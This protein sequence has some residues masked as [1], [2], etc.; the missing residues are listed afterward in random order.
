MSM[1]DRPLTVVRTLPLLIGVVYG[2]HALADEV[3]LEE[4]IVT[5]Q[6]RTERLQDVPLSIS[7]IG[8]S[9]L[10]TRGLE[11]A[12]NIDG[13]VPNVTIKSA[14]STGLIAATAI[15]GLATGQPSIWADPSVGL[16]LDGVFVG[17][18]QGSLFDIA[19]LER[20]EVL[21]GPQG[22]LFGRNTEGGAINFV[23][24]KPGGVFSG[25]V[26]FELGNYGRHVERVSMDLP[27]VGA[28]SISFALR[29]ESQDGWLKNAAGQDFNGKD[30]QAGRLAVSF[31]ISP[32]FKIDYAYDA[33]RI[34]ESPPGMTL[35]D[36]GGYGKYYATSR[37]TYLLFQRGL[38]IMGPG[39]FGPCSASNPLAC[40]LD[41][42]ML[43]GLGQALAATGAAS[44]SYPGT[45]RAGTPGKKYY[46]KLDV[47]GHALTATY[48]L[49]KQ[50]TLKYIGAYRKMDY[51]DM[52]DIDGTTLT[53]YDTGRDTKYSTYSHEFQWV[54]TTDRLNY[55]IGYYQFK[56]DGNSIS[57]NGGDMLTFM[58]PSFGPDGFGYERPGFQ[59]RTHAKALYGQVDYKVTDA[60]TAT[61]G[62]RRTTEK[63]SGSSVRYT[64][65][66]TG[67]ITGFQ[68]DGGTGPDYGT[69]CVP[70]TRHSATDT[71]SANTP[72]LALAYR[73]NEN[74]NVFGRAAK[75]FKSGGFSLEATTIAGTQIPFKPERSTSY[76]V[77]IKTNFWGG[78]GQFNAT[79]FR[80]NVTDLQISQMPPGSNAGAIIVNA[81][82]A[83]SQ[84]I[85]L[86]SAFVLADGWKLQANYGYLD[87]KFRKYLTNNQFG[88]LVDVAANTVSPYAPKSQFNV[89]LDGR[90][91]R[92]SLGTLRGIID[93]THSAKFYN[94][95]GQIS[96]PVGA[97]SPTELIAVANTRDE[98]MMPAITNVNARLLLSGIRV[99]GP[100]A[101]DLSLWVRNLTNSHKMT[102]HIDVGGFY[103]IAT[104]QDPR[105]YGMSLNYKW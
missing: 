20:I 85:E 16:Y 95:A 84:G 26:G 8:G 96:Q 92:T 60:L 79:V 82:S 78:K 19:D 43:T 14:P 37:G 74:V 76:E 22:T 99:G 50:N 93:V 100:G 61:L 41:A 75:G 28:A 46:Q 68:C 15:R 71:S 89:N 18:N 87:A 33:T 6:K 81:G 49:N 2:G 30:R 83:R 73:F 51:R 3:K 39:A 56:D 67:A 63:K 45:I 62:Y 35:V 59:V 80:T 12:R 69:P 44:T 25:N 38:N 11:S 27:K 102:S 5:A 47:D 77:G 94:Y 101:A 72:V 36:S 90:L 91:A 1:Q 55:V 23:T 57:F 64:A 105:M 32:R 65:D 54:G 103:R 7:A 48:E 4:V 88:N 70:W 29:N 13:I 58:P 10:E 24:R 31:D 40:A 34:N 86:E 21:R 42:G 97:G 104:W 9:Q 52:T 98:S 66:A 53:I 17:K